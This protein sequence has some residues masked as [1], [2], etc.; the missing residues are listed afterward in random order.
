MTFLVIGGHSPIAIAISKN[1]SQKSSVI[2]VSRQVDNQLK[3]E[4]N[5]PKVDFEEWDL[6]D[7][8]RCIYN[9]ENLM[10]STDLEGMIFSHRYRSPSD[11]IAERFCVEIDTPHQLTKV[12]AE[13]DEEKYGSVVF[14]TSP[15]ATQVIP[16]QS[17]EYHAS[18]AAQLQLVRFAAAY[19]SKGRKR[20]NGV[21]PGGFVVKDRSRSF[22]AS[23]PDF[24]KKIN[25]FLPLKR[26]VE[27]QEIASAVSFLCSNQASYINGVNLSL[28]GGYMSMEPSS[29][30]HLDY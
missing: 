21:A 20:I 27:V 11:N 1:L 26:V 25:D 13:F 5:S 7:T 4:L 17:F 2:H 15:A 22:Y 14:L 24:M 23:H 29:F 3:K 10:K 30:L 12:Y 9:L 16:D 8:Q 19:Y 6:L 18:K 28:D